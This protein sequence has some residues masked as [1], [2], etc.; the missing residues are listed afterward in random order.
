MFERRAYIFCVQHYVFVPH[1]LLVFALIF[2][3]LVVL[4]FAFILVLFDCFRVK[5]SLDLSTLPSCISRVTLIV[6]AMELASCTTT[7]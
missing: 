4:F 2:V 5:G 6:P 1:F 7:T 3:V